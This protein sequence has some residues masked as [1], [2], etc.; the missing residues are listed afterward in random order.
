L[1]PEFASFQ[2]H[3]AITEVPKTESTNLEFQWA[4]RDARD[5]GTVIHDQLQSLAD[6]VQVNEPFDESRHKDIARQQLRNLGLNESSLESATDKVIRALR[7]TLD[8]ERG[9]WI[10]QAHAEARTEWA[11]TIPRVSATTE[12]QATSDE[13]TRFEQRASV[14]QVII[15]RT[16]VDEQGVRWIVDYKTGDHQGAELEAFLDNEQAR[17]ADQL[18]RYA[19]II[20]RIDERPV[21]VGL[22]FPMLKAWREWQP[23]SSHTGEK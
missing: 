11:L 18:N 9:R 6:T 1:L 13:T 7:N 5:I 23:I 14:Q 21:R 8:D 4:G 10:L 17:Y 3:S 19:D 22:Y 20:T 16:F 12:M 2:W 15:D